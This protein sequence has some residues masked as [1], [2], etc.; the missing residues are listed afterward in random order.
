MTFGEY[1][2]NFMKPPRMEKKKMK[3]NFTSPGK[4]GESL[5]MYYDKLMKAMEIPEGKK[6]KLCREFTCFKRW[7]ILSFTFI[8]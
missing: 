3:H 4:K 7:C 8:F 2:E 5:R 6:K 1:L